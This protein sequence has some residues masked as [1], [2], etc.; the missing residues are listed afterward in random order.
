MLSYD[1][2][3]SS[4]N[5]RSN[6]RLPAHLALFFLKLSAVMV[7]YNA[8]QVYKTFLRGPEILKNFI[9]ETASSL[10]RRGFL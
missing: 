8:G 5:R 6:D 1:K 7:R 9:R 3:N 4:S 2:S 10:T